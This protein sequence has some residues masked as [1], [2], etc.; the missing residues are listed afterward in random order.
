MGGNGSR[1]GDGVGGKGEKLGEVGMVGEDVAA[2]LGLNVFGVSIETVDEEAEIGG[3]EGRRFVE[4]VSRE[5]VPDVY[6]FE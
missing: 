6:G 1:V 5:E 4:I 2:D 3:G